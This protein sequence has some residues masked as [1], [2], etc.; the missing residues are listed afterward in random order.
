MSERRHLNHPVS[1]E[2]TNPDPP[3]VSAHVPG[4]RLHPPAGPLQ[5][6]P[7]GRGPVH[8]GRSEVQEDRRLLATCFFQT[9]R[10]AANVNLL[11]LSDTPWA[12]PRFPS[13]CSPASNR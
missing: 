6:G 11:S 12:T 5:P 3:H 13:A 7:V 8:R 10:L 1:I 2:R 4:G 9:G